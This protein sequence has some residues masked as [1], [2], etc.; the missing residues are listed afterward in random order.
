MLQ[1]DRCITTWYLKTVTFRM[2][3]QFF[4]LCFIAGDSHRICR[5]YRPLYSAQIQSQH[6]LSCHHKKQFPFA[7]I[8]L[9]PSQNN[10]V[11]TQSVCKPF[12][13]YQRFCDTRTEKALEQNMWFEYINP[14]KWIQWVYSNVLEFRQFNKDSQK[15]FQINQESSNKLFIPFLK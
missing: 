14:R 10:T 5:D 13:S 7:A 6:S 12:S 1:I 15:I 9:I 2:C 8:G 3:E 11:I 4:L